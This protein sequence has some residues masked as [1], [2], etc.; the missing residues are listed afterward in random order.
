[1]DEDISFEEALER[2]EKIVQKLEDGG[3]ALEE[4]LKMFEEGVSLSRFCYKKLNE[5]EEKI[6]KLIEKEGGITTEP[7]DFKG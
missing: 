7:F 1:M 3:F 5:A 2:L 6:E 4:S